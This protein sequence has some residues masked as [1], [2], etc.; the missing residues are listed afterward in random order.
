MKKGILLSVLALV[1]AAVV[2]TSAFAADY[3]IKFGYSASD[4]EPN[5]I[6]FVDTFKAY[7]EEASEGKIEVQLFPNAQIGGERQMMEGMTIG[8]IEMAMLSP[9]IAASLAPDFQ[10]IDL[11]YLFNTREAAYKALDGEL[12]DILNEQ[13]VPKGVRLLGFAENGFREIT[14]N[15]GEIKSPADLKGVKIR[16]QPIPAHLA[17]FEALGATPTAIDF[18]ELYTAL[19]QK[20]VDAQENSITL[21]KSSKL[22]EV[23]KFLTM[24]DHVY[25]PSGVFMSQAFYAR[26][27]EDMQKIVNDGAAKFFAQSRINQTK[28]AGE[29]L[30]ELEAEGVKIYYPTDEEMK[31]F[32]EAAM[33]VYD[34]MADKIDRKL[35]DLVRSA[36]D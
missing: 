26:L 15:I 34:V 31:Q 33:K 18:G 8:T 24:S 23:Q 27:P 25:A 1:F 16:V 14:N 11:P 7:V 29:V 28:A 13:L 20:T 10:V 5:Y 35:I 12:R 6:T 2:S 21:I 22:Y 30:K 9:G 17:L 4:K 3:V 36:N 19:L 32:R